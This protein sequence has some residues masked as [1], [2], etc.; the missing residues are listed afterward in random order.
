MELRLRYRVNG[1][2]AGYS[3]TLRH[4]QTLRA[5]LFD[6]LKML[7]RQRSGA[8]LVDRLTGEHVHADFVPIRGWDSGETL[9]LLSALPLGARRQKRVPGAGLVLG[10]PQER[11]RYIWAA[12]SSSN[13]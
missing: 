5:S 11:I 6:G 7:S 9:P 1:S 8:G 2:S 10:G 12:C 13:D 4:R 3:A